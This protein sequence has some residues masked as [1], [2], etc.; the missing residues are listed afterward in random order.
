MRCAVAAADSGMQC[1]L[2]KA[3]PL[4]PHT[5]TAT[6]TTSPVVM[7]SM[8]I[9][10]ELGNGKLLLNSVQLH[11]WLLLGVS[12][13]GNDNRRRSSM[14]LEPCNNY[15]SAMFRWLFLLFARVLFGLLFFSLL[16]STTTMA[17]TTTITTTT[18]WFK[19]FFSSFAGQCSGGNRQP[20][21]DAVCGCECSKF[22]SFWLRAGTWLLVWI[23]MLPVNEQMNDR[24]DEC[25]SLF[26]GGHFNGE[27]FAVSLICIITQLLT[28]C[29]ECVWRFR[30]WD[31]IE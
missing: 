20:M 13:S 21:V 2:T 15:R 19:S 4:P 24:A 17:T 12:Q 25:H 5:A 7:P 14:N 31:W 28:V 11:C 22:I 26:L 8:K 3:K 16:A 1:I 9:R 27:V 23:Q 30:L 6:I 10:V 29:R 18:R